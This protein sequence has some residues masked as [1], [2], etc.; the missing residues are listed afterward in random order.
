MLFSSLVKVETILLLA[1]SNLSSARN[2]L[3]RD[4]S[5]SKL[6]SSP[7]SV[8]ET[9]QDGLVVGHLFPNCGGRG[10]NRTV[11]VPVDRCLT[12]PRLAIVINQA[13][14]CANG[15]RAKWARFPD[16]KCG[17]G[18]LDPRYPLLEIPD[19]D[20]G[21]CLSTDLPAP[22][23]DAD[24]VGRVEMMRSMAFWCEGVKKTNPEDDDKDKKPVEE[25]TNKEKKGTVS[26]SACMRDRA[27][28]YSHPMPDTCVN[29]STEKLQINKAAVCANGT[30]STFALYKQKGCSGSPQTF[31]DIKKEELET[32]FDVKGSQ[33]FAFYCTGED[34]QQDRN[35]N[36][37]GGSIWHFL[38]VLSLIFL[39][40]ALMLVLS[41]LAWVRRYGGSVGKIVEFAKVS[42]FTLLMLLY[43]ANLYLLGLDQTKRWRYSTIIRSKEDMLTVESESYVKCT[44][45]Y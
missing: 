27:P 30:Q 40:F 10:R 1:F 45:M 42:S 14:V 19:S 2:A 11:T 38:L 22:E 20:I 23:G 36:N 44:V 4:D 37:G 24:K 13:A 28:F 8:L 39:M 26:E 3:P 7:A 34:I 35:N 32:C 31:I 29:L 18:E 6:T 9:P 43:Y 16:A 12:I 33:A 5:I 17:H 21:E 15:T 25:P 41:V